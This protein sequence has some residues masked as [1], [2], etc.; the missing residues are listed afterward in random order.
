MLSAL[1]ATGVRQI[2]TRPS[3]K[4]RGNGVPARATWGATA[5][6]PGQ[7]G[8]D[9]GGARHPRVFPVNRAFLVIP[10]PDQ[11]EG[12]LQRESMTF[13]ALTLAGIE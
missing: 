12:R 4:R 10:A 3:A 1:V 13:K 8:D 2:P 11:V 5:W 7:A 9:G 6:V